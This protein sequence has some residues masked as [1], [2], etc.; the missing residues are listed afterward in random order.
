MNSRNLKKTY[1]RAYEKFFIENNI[2]VSAPLLINWAG[3]IL[4]NYSWIWIKQ[5]LP[6]R[7]YV[8]FA[9]TNSG[10]IA[11]NKITHPD[12]YNYWFTESLALEYA[13]YFRDV[14]GF[15]KKKYMHLVEKYGG[16]EINMF[17]E[18]P[19]WVGL[20][21][22]TIVALAISVL[23]KRLEAKIESKDLEEMVTKN[24]NDLLNDSYWIFHEILSEALEFDKY[25]YGLIS[26]GSKLASFFHSHYPII[27]FCEDHDNGFHVNV[28]NIRYF[29]FR[30][31][32]IYDQLKDVPYAPIDYWIIYSGKPV[33]LEEIAGDK[34]KKN[35]DVAEQVSKE[36]SWLFGDFLEHLPPH[37]RPRFYKSLVEH[38]KQEIPE[39]Y[40]KMMGVIS[41]KI[42]FF[43]S[44]VYSNGYDESS[45]LSLLDTFRKLR[46][47]DCCTRNSSTEFLK[48]IRVI[49]E[50]FEWSAKYL[51]LTPNDS[52]I[53]GGAINFMLPL[54]GFRTTIM[55]VIEKIKTKLPWSK[56]IYANR[57]DGLMDEWCKIEQ[58]LEKNQYSEFLAGKNCIMKR[59]NW[60]MVVWDCDTLI[61]TEKE[62]LILDTLNNKMYLQGVKLTSQEL[63]SQVATIEIL[64]MLLENPWK[65]IH[66]KQLPLSSYSK[67]KND[68]YGKIVL[69]LISL[70][71]KKTGKK[72]PLICKG[73][74]YDFSMRLDDSSIEM[75]IINHL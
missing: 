35:G 20:G 6:L 31:N 34:Y 11:I 8:W 70:V 1:F 16:I 40:G 13:P 53:M 58:D 25:M 39:I 9:K 29:G 19:R 48:C 47:T 28:K 22:W 30:L 65:E 26:W 74:L 43:M 5:K 38:G 18:I 72:L 36:V 10:T 56:L 49:I 50:N 73:S 24:I 2:V 66:N 57:L 12:F 63:H 17:S 60:T 62:G 3:D 75:A 68:M 45:M 44:K 52:T 7:I 15:L 59:T 69:P 51:A 23:I 4:N 55:N 33:L 41:L 14:E 37:K 54:E 67:N 27:S 46:Q 71:E 42:L 32:E 21:F 64:K 61:L